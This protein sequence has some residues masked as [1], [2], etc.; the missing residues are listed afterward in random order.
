MATTEVVLQD[1]L[2]LTG[3]DGERTLRK[4][5]LKT[6][7]AGDYL[8]AVAESEQV[9]LTPEGYQLLASDTLLGAHLLRR[10]IVSIDD[11]PGPV[12]LAELRKLSQTDLNILNAAALKLDAGVEHAAGKEL[13]RRGRDQT[14]S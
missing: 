13:T 4:V 3:K 8:D 11:H 14:G 7:A 1:G 12:S 10:Q 6:A 9:K 2:T 5:T